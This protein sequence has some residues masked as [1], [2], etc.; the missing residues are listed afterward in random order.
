METRVDDRRGEKQEPAG[1]TRRRELEQIGQQR[2]PVV[3]ESEGND[4]SGS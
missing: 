4:A 3:S 1:V 2:L